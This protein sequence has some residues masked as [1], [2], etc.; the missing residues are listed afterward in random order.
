MSSIKAD[1]EFGGQNFPGTVDRA[2]R[3]LKR[4][5]CDDMVMFFESTGYG[6]NPEVIKLLARVDR[7]TSEDRVTDGAPAYE[8]K[9][10]AEIIYG[11]K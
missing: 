8:T 6:D 5:G 1:K 11:S 9:S 7:A 10:A 3:A 2:K 4:F